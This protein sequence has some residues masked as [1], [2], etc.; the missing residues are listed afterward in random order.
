MEIRFTSSIQKVSISSY[1]TL[2]DSLNGNEVKM[3]LLLM[4]FW[5]WITG[6]GSGHLEWIVGF[7]MDVKVLTLR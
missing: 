6:T 5:N 3:C 1:Q 7:N 2:P 4:P